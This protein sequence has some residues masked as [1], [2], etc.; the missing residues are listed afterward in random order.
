MPSRCHVLPSAYLPPATVRSPVEEGPVVVAVLRTSLRAGIDVVRYDQLNDEMAKL[1]DAYP[2]HLGWV[3]FPSEEGQITLIRF[4]DQ[5]ALLAWRDD[6][7]HLEVQEIGRRDFFSS[8]HV[9]VLE[10]VRA[11][12]FRHPESTD[13]LKP[14]W[15]AR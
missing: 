3:S 13:T 10:T 14:F 1:L 5:A 4:T 8:Y 7:R 6:P 12:S 9:E 2:G 11:Y 15:D